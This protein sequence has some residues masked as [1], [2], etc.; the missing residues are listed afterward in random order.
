[1]A[2]RGRTFPR[3]AASLSPR[4]RKRVVDLYKAVATLAAVATVLVAAA[5]LWFSH[6]SVLQAENANRI[7]EEALTRDASPAMPSSRSIADGPTISADGTMTY[8]GT[9]WIKITADAETNGR[10]P[11]VDTGAKEGRHLNDLTFNTAAGDPP[12]ALPESNGPQPLL[13]LGLLVVCGGLAG[14]YLYRSSD[15]V[16]RTPRSSSL[17]FRPS[18]RP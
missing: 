16:L 17:G 4:R 14:L 6:M 13:G 2:P 3:I 8:L 11:S 12:A 15:V 9:N 1:M 18:R 5:G 7:A 10:A